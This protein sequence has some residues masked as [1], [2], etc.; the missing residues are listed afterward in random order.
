MSQRRPPSR[1]SRMV[2]STSRRSMR[3]FCFGSVQRWPNIAPSEVR[4][5]ARLAGAAR[6]RNLCEVHAGGRRSVC[7]SKVQSVDQRMRLECDVGFRQLR[8]RHRTRSGQPGA[9]GRDI[10]SAM[11]SK[12]PPEGG[13]SSGKKAFRQ[14]STWMER[15]ERTQSDCPAF[16]R[17]A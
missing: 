5:R 6:E 3:C 8:T 11:G 9:R 2:A 16:S 7:L 10:A 4:D 12:R 1:P 17:L 13:L 14:M 15:L